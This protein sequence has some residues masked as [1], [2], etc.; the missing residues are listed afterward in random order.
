M[1]VI[2][3]SGWSRKALT[4]SPATQPAPRIATPYFFVTSP[5]PSQW[6]AYVAPAVLSSQQGRVR[7]D[8]NVNPRRAFGLRQKTG[9]APGRTGQSPGLPAG[10]RPRRGASGREPWFLGARPAASH[11]AQSVGGGADPG[12]G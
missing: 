9:R 3:V 8:V 5:P 2:S 11:H 4:Y 7:S 10:G 12:G 1:P 6:L